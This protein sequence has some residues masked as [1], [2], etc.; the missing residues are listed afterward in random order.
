MHLTSNIKTNRKQHLPPSTC[1]NWE[2]ET[3]ING[4]YQLSHVITTLPPTKKKRKKKKTTKLKKAHI[5]GLGSEQKRTRPGP[6]VYPNW[7]PSYPPRDPRLMYQCG[8]LPLSHAGSVWFGSPT[9]SDFV[10]L[11]LSIL[12]HKSVAKTNEYWHFGFFAFPPTSLTISSFLASLRRRNYT[13]LQ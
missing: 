6:T 11:H 4:T 13:I 10:S 3:H 12:V 7:R 2:S 1:C 9:P 5:I 8:T